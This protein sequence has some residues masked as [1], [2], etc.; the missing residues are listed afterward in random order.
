MTDSATAS[1]TML[2]LVGE[3]LKIAASEFDVRETP[4]AFLVG[5]YQFRGDAEQRITELEAQDVPSY[6]IEVPYTQGPSRFYVYAGAYSGPTEAAVMR[7]RLRAVGVE[8]TL[9]LRIGR[10]QP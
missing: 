4:L 5:Q 9:V 7:E 3:G 8:D 2:R 6:V 10:S 1:A